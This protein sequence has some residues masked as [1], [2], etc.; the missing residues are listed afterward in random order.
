MK[1]LKRF[2]RDTL[3]FKPQQVQIFTPSPSTVATLMYYTEQSFP[4]A[5]P[6]FVE[7]K[8]EKKEA[9]KKALLS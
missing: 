7:K 2:V 4:E 6:L 3:G 5:V 8:L 1:V 9:Q